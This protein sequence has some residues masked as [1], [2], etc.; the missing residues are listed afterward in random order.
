[1]AARPVKKVTSYT[2]PDFTRLTE[3][4]STKV[5]GRILF[6]TDEWFAAATM[7]L[8]GGQPVWKE[9][10][11]S[12]QGKW[13]DGWE[14]GRKRTPGH[15]WCIVELGIPGVIS[16]FEVDTSFFTGNFVPKISIQA[17]NKL[18]VELPNV[19][20]QWNLEAGYRATPD[21]YKAVALL[22]SEKWV[23]LLPMTPLLPGYED[24]CRNFFEVSS[25]SS[26]S[27]LRVNIYPDGGIARLR[28]FG[29]VQR[30][31]F[32]KAPVD[33]LVDLCSVVNGAI[34]IAWSDVHFGHPINM[35]RPGRGV[36]MGDGWE[37]ARHLDRPSVLYSDEHGN[38][39]VPGCDW[40]VL[41]LGIAGSVCK[42]E[43]DT[44][45]F[46]GNFP[47]SCLI[48]GCNAPI[49]KRPEILNA[50]Q[51]EKLG[52]WKVLLP[53]TKLKA[54]LRHYFKIMPSEQVTHIRLTIYPDGGVS[55]L[56]VYGQPNLSS[57]AAQ[58]SNL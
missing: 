7:M 40:T 53:R 10:V 20:D 52:C 15:D 50:E 3:L 29:D 46:K 11:Y 5:G 9:G 18:A 54:H 4:A 24:T 35:L 57:I 48:E 27:H 43:V 31:W 34:P 14:S 37:T 41:Q 1:M 42:F 21:D 49:K 8:S 22:E 44:N 39:K 2:V 26:W 6:A 13:M 51:C 25:L 30:D 32:L 47:E 45:H 16:G 19:L 56:R 55:R 58:S 38:L 12:S 36:D 33:N 17:T 28:V 23:E